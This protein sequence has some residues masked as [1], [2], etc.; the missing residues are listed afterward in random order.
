[1]SFRFLVP[2]VLSVFATLVLVV[3]PILVSLVALVIQA[4]LFALV[5]FVVDGQPERLAV[6]FPGLL[7]GWIR[8]R[9]GGIGAAILFHALSNLYA[10]VL[11]RGWLG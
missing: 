7:F 9:R 2:T 6:F 10:D 3:T 11:V 5:H 4:A 8:A 1:M